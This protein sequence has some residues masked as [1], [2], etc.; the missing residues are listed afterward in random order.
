MGSIC[1]KI[2]LWKFPFTQWQAPVNRMVL[3]RPEARSLM[4]MW[5]LS[6]QKYLQLFSEGDACIQWFCYLAYSSCPSRKIWWMIGGIA[7]SHGRNT[8]GC[9]WRTSSDFS[10][11]AAFIVMS[12]FSILRELGLHTLKLS[13][14]WRKTWAFVVHMNAAI[15][16]Q[17]WITKK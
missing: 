16:R 11:C 7:G 2:G 1:W 12:T 15:T 10:A 3:E 8:G 5:D 14:T 4:E 13:M 17:S 9:V 6:G